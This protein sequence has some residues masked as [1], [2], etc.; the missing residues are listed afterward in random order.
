MHFPNR[1]AISNPMYYLDYGDSH[2]ESDQIRN[3]GASGYIR[4]DE[5]QWAGVGPLN[6]GV[7]SFGIL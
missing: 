6:I 2:R 7:I 3:K 4:Q 1:T 5:K